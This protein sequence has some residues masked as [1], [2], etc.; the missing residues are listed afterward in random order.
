M[1]PLKHQEM[2]ND[3]ELQR[4]GLRTNDSDLYE[5]PEDLIFKAY[6]TP[7]E[8]IQFTKKESRPNSDQN[9]FSA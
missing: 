5:M 4:I 3:E 6:S 9:Y 8:T 1:Y 7:Q 2:V